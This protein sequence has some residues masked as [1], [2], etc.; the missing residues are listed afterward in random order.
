MP[1]WGTRVQFARVSCPR[2]RVEDL[3]VRMV[4]VTH[5]DIS[6]FQTE[7][8]TERRATLD[9]RGGWHFHILAMRRACS[10]GDR[11]TATT[12]S[13]PRTDSP[14][15]PS[16][17]AAALAASPSV[18]GA[19]VDEIFRRMTGS[20]DST[21]ISREAFSTYLAT[22]GKN[23]GEVE[24]AWRGLARDGGGTVTRESVKSYIAAC[25]RPLRRS[26]SRVHV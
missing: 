7:F 19:L 23:R 26:T 20:S 12:P 17:A 8:D 24:S 5:R 6:Y 13:R 4:S 3:I 21:A 14:P 22:S 25:T 2:L 10:I 9:C 18:E 15:A 16:P 11:S 1:T